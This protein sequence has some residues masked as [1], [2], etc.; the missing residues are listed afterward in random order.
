[1]KKMTIGILLMSFLS[2]PFDVQAQGK[3]VDGI[4]F[5]AGSGALIGQAIGRNTEATLIGTAVGTMLGYIVGNEM[6][7]TD[8]G[9]QTVST[10]RPTYSP[11]VVDRRPRYYYSSAPVPE[12]VQEIQCQQTEM[13]ATINGRPEKITGTACWEDGRWIARSNDITGH[14]VSSKTRHQNYRTGRGNGHYKQIG[15]KKYNRQNQR[16]LYSSAW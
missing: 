13:L 1:M 14:N 4:F 3:G 7:K 2:L 11:P 6:E 10:P 8:Y 16:T 15:H 9:R 5:G 12:P